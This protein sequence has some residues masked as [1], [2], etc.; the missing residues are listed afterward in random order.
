MNG[1]P[2]DA[3]PL[4]VSGS[5][6]TVNTDNPRFGFEYFHVREGTYR[7]NRTHV[8]TVRNPDVPRWRAPAPHELR[9]TIFIPGGGTYGADDARCHAEIINM[10]AAFLDSLNESVADQ[11]RI[12]EERAERE[13]KEYEER[14]AREREA[15]LARRAEEAKRRLQLDAR[16]NHIF[17][18]IK[19]QLGEKIKLTRDGKRATVFGTIDHVE[20][21][22]MN[23]TTE[24]GKFMRIVF[25]DVNKLWIKEGSAR[26]YSVLYTAGDEPDI[27]E[28]KEEEV[29]A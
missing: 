28:T 2:P 9:S 12:I 4:G 24:K 17:E 14:R 13:R 18:L 3:E 8:C 11:I 1:L 25:R 15:A 10:A 5:Y 20:P 21:S 23:I 6:V 16:G 7:W 29:T 19:W 26:R 27:T 22:F